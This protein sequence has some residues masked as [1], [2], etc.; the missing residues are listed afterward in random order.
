[1]VILAICAA[2]NNASGLS[3]GATNASNGSAS[4]MDTGAFPF[5]VADTRDHGRVNRWFLFNFHEGRFHP[6]L[7][8]LIT[9]TSIKRGHDISTS[10]SHIRLSLDAGLSD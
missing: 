10:G 5:T 3:R 6:A 4:T 9:K 8:F 7:Y 1:M 2:I